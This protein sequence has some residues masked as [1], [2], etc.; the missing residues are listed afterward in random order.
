[1]VGSKRGRDSPSAERVAQ[2]AAGFNFFALPVLVYQLD[3]KL[4]SG[5]D[6]LR[7]N[8][9]RSVGACARIV[10][11]QAIDRRPFA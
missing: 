6:F 11:I 5:F 3:A 9:S 2:V 8:F 4:K 10:K 7:R 1:M